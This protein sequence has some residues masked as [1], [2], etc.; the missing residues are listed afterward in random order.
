[1][2]FL[3]FDANSLGYDIRDFESVKNFADLHR[4]EELVVITRATNIELLANNLSRAVFV[5]Y[6]KEGLRPNPMDLASKLGIGD[7]QVL[8]FAQ[9]HVYVTHR[10]KAAD[11]SPLPSLQPYLF[12]QEAL[13]QQYSHQLSELVSQSAPDRVAFALISGLKPMSDVGETV[14]ER[15]EEGRRQT[16][17]FEHVFR[18]TK[19]VQAT[20]AGEGVRVM[21]LCVQYGPR[22]RV[23]AM[24]DHLNAEWD[25]LHPVRIFEDVDWDSHVHQQ[26]AFYCALRR[27]GLPIVVYG[28]AA[29]FLHVLLATVGQVDAMAIALHGYSVSHAR[30][31]RHYWRSACDVLPT[32]KLFEQTVP[33]EWSEVSRRM[34][35][36]ITA[37]LMRRFTRGA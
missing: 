1:M 34:G 2:P 25:L 13:V 9:T 7:S 4:H 35:E 18:V 30:D 6:P 37:A 27:L 32:L 23:R 21:P 22:S 29:S 10:V 28:N 24:L 17:P 16:L 8:S 19:N 3:L 11:G 33:G 5:G 14:E 26:A 12:P 36:W 20:L 31:G 15:L